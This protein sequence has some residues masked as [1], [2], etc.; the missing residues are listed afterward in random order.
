MIA[1]RASSIF[2]WW[3]ILWIFLYMINITTINPFIATVM[4]VVWDMYGWFIIQS[5]SITKQPLD[6]ILVKQFR[7]LCI[8]LCH[9]V[10]F[11]TL[12]VSITITS[13]FTLI[14]LLFIYILYLSILGLTPNSVYTSAMIS[15]KGIRSI[16]QLCTMRFRYIPLAI[17]GY[18]IL[19]YNGIQLLMKPYKGSL[20]RMI[21]E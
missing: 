12:P 2:T 8:L 10:P 7:F 19:F 14:G 16:S 5:T 3:I 21:I 17:V 13:L 18:G 6:V 20:I 9:W 11:F 4:S 1:E 15:N